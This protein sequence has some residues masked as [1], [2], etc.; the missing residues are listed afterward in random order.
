MGQIICRSKRRITRI[1]TRACA[2]HPWGFPGGTV[3]KNPSASAGGTRD[4]GSARKIHWIR[5]WQSTPIFLPGKFHGQSSLAGYSPWGHKESDMTEWLTTFHSYSA[6]LYVYIF[7]DVLFFYSY[8]WKQYVKYANIQNQNIFV[9]HHI[10]GNN[11]YMNKHYLWP[12]PLIN[13]NAIFVVWVLLSVFGNT[14]PNSLVL[15]RKIPMNNRM[16]LYCSFESHKII[17]S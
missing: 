1:L 3:G 10:L 2:F 12:Y 8:Y 5:K 9:W 17:N 15:F 14:I 13:G 4:V 6:A 11:T 16:K 7:N